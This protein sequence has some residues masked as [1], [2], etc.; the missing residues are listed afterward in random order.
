MRNRR[1]TVA[2]TYIIRRMRA[3]SPSRLT[4]LLLL[5]LVTTGCSNPLGKQYEYEE[6][7]YLSV[8]GSATL[9]IDSSIPALVA[10]RKLPL[11]PSARTPVDRDQ[12][13]RLYATAGCAEVRVGQSWM[14]HGRR[15]VQI[16]VQAADV[17]ELASCGPVSWS[18]FQFERQQEGERAIVHYTQTVGASADG[19]P[20]AVNWN[21]SELVGFKLHLPSRIIFHNVKRPDGTNGEPDRGNILT[22]EQRL[23]DRRAGQPVSMEVRMD[24]QSILHRTL[25]LFAGAFVA[26]MMV[27]M[28]LVWWTI[29]RAKKTVGAPH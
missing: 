16:R 19:D 4:V 5:L 7:L 3:W 26:A 27:I 9:V 12:V 15:F 11:D 1:G 8:D 13:M 17:T 14:R 21:G 25:W 20:G 2:E 23:A 18:S 6:Q 10:L 24:S 22:Y 29:R 28:T